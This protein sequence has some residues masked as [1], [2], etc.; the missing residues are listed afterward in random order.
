MKR[1]QYADCKLISLDFP[2]A[3]L[4]SSSNPLKV[5]AQKAKERAERECIVH[6]LQLCNNDYSEASK[7][8]NISLSSLYRKLK[9]TE[10]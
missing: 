7:I 1:I 2:Y 10:C 6:V 8:L 9:D 3:V 4:L 5:V